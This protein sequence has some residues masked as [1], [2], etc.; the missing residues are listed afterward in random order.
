[1]PEMEIDPLLCKQKARA[2]VTEWI[3][4]RYGKEKAYNVYITAFTN[5]G[6]T[7]KAT[8]HTSLPNSAFFTVEYYA[9]KQETTMRVYAMTQTVTKYSRKDD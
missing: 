7:W 4:A 9:L 1:M 5:V 8:L 2:M 3:D 6:K